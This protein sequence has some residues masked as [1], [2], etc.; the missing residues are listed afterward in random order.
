MTPSI[1]L[2][3][4]AVVLALGCPM[5]LFGM[6]GAA[7]L[8][9]ERWTEGAIARVTGTSMLICVASLTLAF[10][11]HL[12]HGQAAEVWTARQW[13]SSGSGAFRFDVLVDTWSLA[14]ALLAAT[15]CGVVSA[16]SARYLHRDPGFGRYFTLFAG[17]TAG[18]LLV[19]LAGSVEV[20]FAGWE[21]IGLSS[22]LL[23]GFFHD[24]RTPVVNAMRVFATY[25]FS[26]AAM[27]TAAAVLHHEVGSGRLSALFLTGD[28]GSISDLS[29]GSATVIGLLLIVAVAGKSALLP[30]SGWLPRAM[31]GPTPSSA[32]YYGGLSVHAGCYLLIRAE[33]VFDASVVARCLLA[34]IGVTTALYATLVARVQ[35]D[36]KSALCF[37]TLTQ[38]GIIVVEIAVGLRTLAFFHMIGHVCLR[39][40]QFLS[41]PNVLQDV[42]AFETAR[43]RPIALRKAQGRWERRLYL[44]GLE[45]GFVDTVVDRCIV[46]P[47]HAIARFGDRIDR[48]L[49]GE[50]PP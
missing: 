13:F 31:E 25:R 26:D 6:L 33:P 1:P 16:F 12:L 20:L 2:L 43:S 23:V 10:V 14:F 3:H 50:T 4:A 48:F 19:A 36:V 46:A 15:L 45:R 42:A 8:V 30:F 27:L 44:F 32:V 47:F 29:A 39:L 18:I 5:V 7:S 28:E 9:P 49:A 21:L 37:A 35:S 17:F 34:A 24:R 38:V 40:L 41:A 11:V 22:T